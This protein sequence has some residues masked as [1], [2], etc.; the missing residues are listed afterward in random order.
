MGKRTRRAG[1]R[2]EKSANSNLQ[3][4]KAVAK[5]NVRKFQQDDT[6]QRERIRACLSLCFLY[7]NSNGLSWDT[8]RGFFMPSNRVSDCHASGATRNENWPDSCKVKLHKGTQGNWRIDMLKTKILRDLGVASILCLSVGCSEDL[9]KCSGVDG[10]MTFSTAYFADSKPKEGFGY[11]HLK[12]YSH[13][14]FIIQQV[15]DDNAVVVCAD[16]DMNDRMLLNMTSGNSWQTAGAVNHIRKKAQKNKGALIYT[17]REYGDGEN[18][19]FGVYV[20]RGRE[21]FELLD[22]GSVVMKVFAEVAVDKAEALIRDYKEIMAAEERKR[23]QEE[24]EAEKKAEAERVRA[25]IARMEAHRIE[26]KEYAKQAEMLLSSLDLNIEQHILVPRSLVKHG[27]MPKLDS[28]SNRGKE[29]EVIKDA[30]R[31][32]DWLA[33]IEAMDGA[34]SS[35]RKRQE[36]P[37]PE[38]VAD[39]VRTYCTV[40]KFDVVLTTDASKCKLLEDYA[41]IGIAS[42]QMVRGKWKWYDTASNLVEGRYDN[43]TKEVAVLVSGISLNCEKYFVVPYRIRDSFSKFWIDNCRKIPDISF[44]ANDEECKSIALRREQL[45]DEFNAMAEKFLQEN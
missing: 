16:T 10:E 27:I 5:R 23:E 39:I 29:L 3:C 33:M 42:E 9:A 17:K 30:Q 35:A 19:D 6:L 24:A 36:Y 15:L 45:K 18:L 44:H 12:D 31:R 40:V 1:A 43:R 37:S 2:A 25:E 22:G 7:G 13:Y 4:C 41:A 28:N 11:V 21:K 26:Q 14:D 38:V 34:T 32:K 20:Y 8:K